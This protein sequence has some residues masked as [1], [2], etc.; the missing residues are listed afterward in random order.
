[1]VAI[2]LG[3]RL[4][5][6]TPRL[7]H[8]FEIRPDL[9]PPTVSIVSPAP[10]RTVWGIATVVANAHDDVA[11]R[12]VRFQ[13]DGVDLGDVDVEPPYEAPWDTT[14]AG[15]GT[16]VVTATAIDLAGNESVVG[17]S[18][19]D[20]AQEAL[21]DPAA[22]GQWAG[23]FAW[24]LVS[25]HSTLLPTGKVLLY[26]DHTTSAGV[27]IWDPASGTLT[28]RPYNA[29]N[30][31]C[32]AHIV[33]ANG[34]VLV[35]GGHLNAYLGI[36]DSTIFDPVA[37]AWS[38]GDT[39]TYARWYPSLTILP[40]GKALVVSGAINCPTCNGPNGSHAGIALVPEVY[41]TP[42]D[43]WSP[44]PGASLSLPL[45]PHLFVIP[46]G[47][48]VAAS[49][50]EDPIATRVLDV[51][52]QTWTVVDPVVRQGGSSV[53]YRPGKILKTGSARNPDYNAANAAATAYVLDMSSPSPSWR[54]VP[55]MAF[56]RTQHNLTLLPDGNVLV[57]GGATNSDVFNTAVAVKTAEM[58]SP[59]A[60]TFTSL[61]TMSEPRQYH[62]TS[63]LL[64][65]GRVLVAGGGRFGPDFPSAEIYSPPYLF[66]GPRPTITSVSPV[67]QYGNAFPV[68][69][70]SAATVSRVAL[71]GTGAVTHAF[72]AHQ[73]YLELP[74]TQ[75]AGGLSVTAPASGNDA[76]PGYYMLFLVDAIG[77]PSVG[78]IVKL[79]GP[80]EDAIP[81]TAPSGLAASPLPGR[82]TLTW[83]A[84]TDNIAVTQYNVHRSP[85]AGF[86]PSPAN[87]VGQTAS[88]T[89]D[90][91]GFASGTYWYLVTAQDGNGNVGPPSN[92]ATTSATEDTTPPA[93]TLT[94]P[95][96]GTIVVGVAAITASA[97]D[98]IGVAG[99]QFL[100][101]G[102]TFGAEDTSFPWSVAWNSGLSSNG[103][104]TLAARARDARGNLTTS[105]PVDVTASNSQLQGLVL[106]YALDEASGATAH[107]SSGNQN[108][109]TVTN[110]LWSGSG[111]TAGALLFDGS[112]DYVSTPSSPSLN[113]SGQGLT[114]ETWANI[115]SS[116]STDYVLI[117]KP[118]TA[119]TQGTPPYQF[120][121]EFDANGAKTLDF[122]FG[123]TNGATRGPFSMSPPLGTWTHIAYT[124]DGAMVRGYVDGAL[125]VSTAAAGSIQAR[126]TPLQLGVDGGLNQGYKGRLDDVRIYNRAL[127]PS[128]LDQDRATPV[129][130]AIPPVPDGSPGAPMR[131]SRGAVATAI[132]LTWDVSG[133]AP[134]GHHVVYGA[135]SG[136][137]SYQV[138]GGVCGIGS[139]GS[140]SWAGVPAGDLWFV[141]VGDNGLTTEGLWA[142]T[143]SGGPMNATTPSLT[144]GMTNRINLTACP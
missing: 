1:V 15:D 127:S 53:M 141:V 5:A 96:P 14:A 21:A 116:S 33:L 67:L 106:S 120:G 70:P 45:Y 93:V 89:F 77:V 23:P 131:A 83:A 117:G 61:A 57:V 112:G 9:E 42:N 92:E 99:V 4:A 54:S 69:S 37:L 91:T 81:P 16:H 68:S 11:L 47:R 82:V 17:I 135:L 140:F 144:C 115:T 133:C 31:F 7:N 46:D 137:P 12:G 103:P 34:K 60:E 87:R 73:R 58:W 13:V 98:D 74:F 122:Y 38:A 139:T 142:T 79:P 97:S 39:M 129:L 64:P 59:D 20:V 72:D 52:A 49:T 143:S 3:L 121:I 88:T 50:Q 123:D 29:S 36:A 102:Q 90:D 51:A 2:F 105:A 25:V 19:V 107:D 75:I 32:S 27:Q 62:S 138:A 108:R 136:L 6:V 71:L 80:W 86:V 55:S 126:P 63:L 35:A 94:A 128:E 85:A 101:D 109:G 76:P 40:D 104:H 134:A 41:D 10:G 111:H 118:W 100:L 119:G 18:E 114:I 113:V 132:D 28:S 8:D 24:P 78:S 84:A 30:L 22:V 56:A 65:D 95:A 130:A 26:D 48:V 43:S 110:A 44:L 125:K 124:F 66:K